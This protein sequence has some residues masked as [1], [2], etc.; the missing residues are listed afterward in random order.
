LIFWVAAVF[1]LPVSP[2]WPP[3]R[4]FLPY[5]RPNLALAGILVTIFTTSLKYI[6]TQAHKD[7]YRWV[8]R[9]AEFLMKFYCIFQSV[10]RQT[11]FLTICH[12][13]VK[14]WEITYQ[15]FFIHSV[16]FN[17][18]FWPNIRVKQVLYRLLFRP[19]GFNKTFLQVSYVKIRF[20]KS[21]K[22]QLLQTHATRCVTPIMFSTKVDGQCGELTTVIGLSWQHLQ[23]STCCGEIFCKS[24]VWIKLQRE[25]GD[26]WNSLHCYSIGCFQCFDTVGCAPGRASG[27]YE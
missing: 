18:L 20:W 10:C 2:I 1:L 9:V 11:I 3:R 26:T 6:S 19:E 25:F 14:L 21:E 27:L 17:I 8:W 24:R 16:H 23:R 15:L 12:H 5:G 22:S 13:S 7:L 4:P